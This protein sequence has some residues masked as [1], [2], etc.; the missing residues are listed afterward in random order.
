MAGSKATHHGRSDV[1]LQDV[2]TPLLLPGRILRVSVG[3]IISAPFY[4]A[5]YGFVR[6]D[7]AECLQRGQRVL[8]KPKELCDTYPGRTIYKGATTTPAQSPSSL[9]LDDF[10]LS[11]I[12]V[13]PF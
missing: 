7:N 3:P 12:M 10:R 13:I 4:R 5:P 8:E 11:N 6:I 1:L 9:K 2:F